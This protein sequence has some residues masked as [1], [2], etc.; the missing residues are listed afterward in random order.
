MSRSYAD[1][2]DL[3]VEALRSAG[4]RVGKP[5]REHSIFKQLSAEEIGDRLSDRDHA[6]GGYFASAALDMLHSRRSTLYLHGRGSLVE[7][8]TKLDLIECAW[9]EAQ[10]VL[11]GSRNIESVSRAAAP[12]GG[13]IIVD[14]IQAALDVVNDPARGQE[15]ASFVMERLLHRWSRP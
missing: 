6:M 3:I 13:V 4:L 9:R 1:D 10:L 12:R 5:S 15:Q 8:R 2:I 11:V 7:L 14:K